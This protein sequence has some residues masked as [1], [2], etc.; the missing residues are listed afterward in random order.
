MEKQKYIAAFTIKNN[1]RQGMK[2]SDLVLGY[3]RV[4]E[5]YTD[6]SSMSEE[7]ILTRDIKIF[8]FE[9]I[10]EA[11]NDIMDVISRESVYRRE[12]VWNNDG[13]CDYTLVDAEF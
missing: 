10:E 6:F 5:F 3:T 2:V 1:D 8:M 11:L 7:E 9:S 12:L 4:E 13:V